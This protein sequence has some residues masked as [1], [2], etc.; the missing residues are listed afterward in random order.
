MISYTAG[1]IRRL[2]LSLI[3]A[4]APDPAHVWSWSAWRRK[5]QDQA[6]LCHH[7]RRGY[8]LT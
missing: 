8:P 5:R 6:R 4:C 3:H 2:L 7:R 1:E